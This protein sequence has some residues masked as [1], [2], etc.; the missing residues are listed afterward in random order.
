[1]K[2]GFC[3]LLALCVSALCFVGCGSKMSDAESEAD[4]KIREC[5][6]FFDDVVFGELSEVASRKNAEEIADKL[7]EV[8]AQLNDYT[9]YFL[10]MADND[11]LSEEQRQACLKA[12]T[13]CYGVVSS[14]LEPARAFFAG[15]GV[16]F[17][18]KYQDYLIT[19]YDYIDKARY[20]I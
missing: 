18:D 6:D 5:H 14:A 11:E 12:K 9:D 10:E 13:A 2:K 15:E 16:D 19:A 1:M 17:P 20:K 8:I 4:A 3:L 7:E